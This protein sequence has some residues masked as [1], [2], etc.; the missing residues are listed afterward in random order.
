MKRRTPDG[1]DGPSR[2]PVEPVGQARLLVLQLGAVV[3]KLL[4]ARVV[5]G[6]LYAAQLLQLRVQAISEVVTGQLE[7]RALAV[8]GV[9]KAEVL[10]Q[11]ILSHR[12][13]CVVQVRAI[14]FRFKSVKVS[15]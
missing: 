9:D 1:R 8:A 7:G 12:L 4:R 2:A 5:R 10:H 11:E 14:V 6:K 15:I 13:F 3:R